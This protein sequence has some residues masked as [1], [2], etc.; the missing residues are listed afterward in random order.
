MLTS[1]SPGTAKFCSGGGGAC[2]KS[3]LFISS[4]SVKWFNDRYW[5]HVGDKSQDMHNNCDPWNEIEAKRIIEEQQGSCSLCHGRF[6]EW[7]TWQAHGENMTELRTRFTPI[8]C[9]KILA[10]NWTV[11]WVEHWLN[12]SCDIWQGQQDFKC[13]VRNGRVRL[14]IGHRTGACSLPGG[15][16]HRHHN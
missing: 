1:S 8:W 11:T 9:T 6:N 3:R 5:Q 13:A 14:G 15:Q 4:S 12:S 16:G 7:E 2:Q 10:W